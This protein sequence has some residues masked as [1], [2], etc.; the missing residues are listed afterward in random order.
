MASFFIVEDEG[1]IIEEIKI[2]L[3]NL[4]HRTLGYAMKSE[5]ALE[6]I[7]NLSPNIVLLDINIKGSQDGIEIAQKINE[8]L[9]IP[10]IFLTALSD[11]DTLNRAKKTM[12]YGYIV[13]PFNESSLKANIEMAIFKFESEHSNAPISK[14]QV[15]RNYKVVLSDREFNILNSFLKGVSYKNAAK[16]NNISVNTVKTYQKKL[17][18]IFQV[19]SKIELIQKL[20]AK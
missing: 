2:I 8:E 13:K 17:Y 14:D 12:P 3:S 6:L 1:L 15:E 19:K 4:G 11:E 10:F 20:N 16:E 7:K 5:R 9:Q 18:Q